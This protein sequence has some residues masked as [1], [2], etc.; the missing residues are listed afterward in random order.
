MIK[1]YNIFIFYKRL[2]TGSLQ[3]LTEK[4]LHASLQ[5]LSGVKY[6]E[7]MQGWLITRVLSIICF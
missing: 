7:F 2:S 4:N 1:P 3:D 6:C 5:L